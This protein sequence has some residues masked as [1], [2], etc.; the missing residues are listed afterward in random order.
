MD[1]RSWVWKDLYSANQLAALVLNNLIQSGLYVITFLTTHNLPLPGSGKIPRYLK[2]FSP[3]TPTVYHM[4]IF[5]P[6][7]SLI[8]NRHICTFSLFNYVEENLRHTGSQLPVS[9]LYR[10]STIC[11]F[12]QFSSPVLFQIEKFFLRSLYPTPGFLLPPVL[13][14]EIFIYLIIAHGFLSKIFFSK[15]GGFMSRV[16]C[17]YS[18]LSQSFTRLEDFSPE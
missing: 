8:S 10:A 17:I 3:Q 2:K 11:F 4:A 6:T 16:F 1:H 13:G 12:P 14:W 18:F 9:S 15:L 5:T 7:S